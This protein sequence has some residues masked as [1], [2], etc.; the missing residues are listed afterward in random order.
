MRARGQTPEAQVALAELCEGYYQPV[1]RF[2]LREGRDQDSASE[3]TQEFF[4]R[5]LGGGGFEAADPQRGRFRSY[6]LGSLKHF[7]ADDRKRERRLKRGGGAFTESLDADPVDGLGEPIQI[8]DPSAKVPESFFDRQWAMAVMAHG[9][10]ELQN[11]FVSEGK[12]DQFDLLKPWLVGEVPTLT[13]ADAARSL[14]LSEGAVK[15]AIHR[16]RKRFREAIRSKI[17]QTLSDPAMIDEELR[18]LI[19]ALI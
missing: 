6:L 1:F 14:G 5:I 8:A 10:D 11:Q 9:L 2:L 12:A 7:L 16:L 18:H 15:V 17:A 3:L 19:E 13:Q 4:A